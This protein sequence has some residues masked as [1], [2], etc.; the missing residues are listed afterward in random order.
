[1]FEDQLF[2]LFLVISNNYSEVVYE[3]AYEI[4]L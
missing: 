3:A 2:Y 4:Y 1:M